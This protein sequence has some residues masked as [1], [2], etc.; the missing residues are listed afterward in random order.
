M[1]QR[2]TEHRSNDSVSRECPWQGSMLVGREAAMGGVR[3][4]NQN[5]SEISVVVNNSLNSEG[6]LACSKKVF[7]LK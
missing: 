4:E 3:A 2:V 1:L 6:E 7:T 5:S